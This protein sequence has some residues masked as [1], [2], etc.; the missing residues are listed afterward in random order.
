MRHIIKSHVCRYKIE[1][2]MYITYVNDP[3]ANGRSVLVI[4]CFTFSGN[5]AKDATTILKILEMFSRERHMLI[6]SSS[7]RV[8]FLDVLEST[9]NVFLYDFTNLDSTCCQQ[10]FIKQ[11]SWKLYINHLH[12]E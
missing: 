10:L 4:N 5:K 11:L 7:L 6:K 8:T 2:N 1:K 3:N 12:T 9:G